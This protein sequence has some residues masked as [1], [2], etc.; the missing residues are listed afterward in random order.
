M[1]H[2][3][4]LLLVRHGQST[5][6]AR[7]IWQGQMEFPLSEEGRQ[8][9]V[10]A[11][12]ALVGEDLRAVYASPLA[13]AFETAGIIARESGFGGEVVPI[14]GLM[15]RHGG[16][17]EGH[18]WEEQK[19]MNPDFAEKFLSI[20]EE[21][22]WSLAGAE[23]DEEVMSRFAKAIA[24][25]RARHPDGG[26]IV[27]V[28]HGGAMRAFLRDLFGP[29]TLPGTHRT[30][31]ASITRIRWP[32]NGTAPELLDLASTRHLPHGSATETTRAE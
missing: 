18:T 22:R 32:D 31:N 6:N 24:G 26:R 10:R 8:Q 19:Q 28:S 3:Q 5:A 2:E 14:P 25:I 29:K 4:E 12:Q 27:V 15:E 23:T 13:R 30:A 21:E 20:P 1:S 11:G 7:G 16:I 9:A 17:L